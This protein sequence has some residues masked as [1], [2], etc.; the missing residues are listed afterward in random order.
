MFNQ[1][2][3]ENAYDQLA[4]AISIFDSGREEIYYRDSI[5]FGLYPVS[6]RAFVEHC[7]SPAQRVPRQIVRK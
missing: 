6:F 2:E 5:L 7:P 1:W 3:E 4:G